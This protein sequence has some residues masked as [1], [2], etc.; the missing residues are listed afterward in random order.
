MKNRFFRGLLYLSPHLYVAAAIAV[1]AVSLA[2]YIFKGPLTYLFQ[3]KVFFF[4]VA[5]VY[6]ITEIGLVMAVLRLSHKP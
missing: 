4:G 6:I 5:G 2:D 3:L 1:L